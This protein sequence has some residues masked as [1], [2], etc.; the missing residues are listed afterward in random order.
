MSRMRWAAEVGAMAFALY[1]AAPIV[2]AAQAFPACPGPLAHLLA[3]AGTYDQGAVLGDPAVSASLDGLLGPEREHLQETLAVSGSIDLV[4][5]HLVISGNA[6]HQGG[7]RMGIV[8]VSLVTGGVSAA[9]RSG[10]E[11]VVY[12]AA[13]EVLDLPLAI[14]DWMAVVATELRYR[15][16]LPPGARLQGPRGAGLP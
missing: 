11:I 14:R 10:P 12:S 7:E 13:G 9:L 6:E 5:C 4:A 2:A 3:Y 15:F 16:S 8:A 1:G